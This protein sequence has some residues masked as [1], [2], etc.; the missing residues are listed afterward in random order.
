MNPTLRQSIVTLIK[1]QEW[2]VA[3]LVFATLGILKKLPARKAIRF[4]D[5]MARKIGPRTHRHKLALQNLELAFPEK[6]EEEREAIALDM[7]GNMARL[8]A[9][10]ILIDKLIDSGIDTGQ[11]GLIEVEGIDRFLDLVE[12]PRPFIVFTAHTGNFEL[13][14]A[15][16]A[17]YGLN[18]TALFRPPNNRYIANKLLAARRT[19]MGNLVP[20]RAGA[21]WNLAGVLEEN[22]GVGLLV[23]QKFRKGPTVQFFG[24]DVIA[25][26]LL[27]KLARHFDCEVF[28]ARC[29]RI[30]ND[31]F[32]LEI[33]EP[34][35]MPRDSDGNVDVQ[36]ASQIVND[37]VESWI[38]EYPGQWMWFHDRWGDPRGFRID[39]QQL[40]RARKYF[41]KNGQW[42]VHV[43]RRKPG[44]P[45]P[46]RM[47]NS[48]RP[49]GQGRKKPSIE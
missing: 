22:R 24:R 34:I 44:Q 10:Y 16:A 3:Q 1:I 43:R 27:A 25:N 7:W 15:I 41:E 19:H 21:A 47:R 2:L 30:E 46:A 38:R 39:P 6:S 37:K 23:D 49:S 32:R 8:M 17:R 31:R 20:S 33:E 45:L 40:A 9:E 36:A 11:G 14:P 48:R 29:I 4:T 28:P 26:P 12:R 5:Y 18:V 42:P 13:L 35:T